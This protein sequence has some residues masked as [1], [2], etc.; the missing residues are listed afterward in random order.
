MQSTVYTPFYLAASST[1]TNV[2]LQTPTSEDETFRLP[3]KL[4]LL[5]SLNVGFF[6]CLTSEVITQVTSHMFTIIANI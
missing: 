3:T 1:H 4:L 6:E 2:S 5:Q